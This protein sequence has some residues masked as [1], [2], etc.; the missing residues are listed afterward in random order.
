MIGPGRYEIVIND[1]ARGLKHSDT[2]ST[3][4]FGLVV[5]AIVAQAPPWIRPRTQMRQQSSF[6]WSRR[7]QRFKMH[8]A[9]SNLW[10]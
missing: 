5:K 1:T 9:H 10:Q 3:L 7:D 4:A 6:T 8:K 2:L